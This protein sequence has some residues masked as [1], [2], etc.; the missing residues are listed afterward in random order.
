MSFYKQTDID[1]IQSE[2]IFLTSRHVDI[3][4]KLGTLHNSLKTSEARG[5][6]SYGVMRRTSVIVRSIK[7]VFA[8][9][10]IDRIELLSMD[11]LHDIDINMHAFYVNIFGLLDNLAWVLIHEKKLTTKIDKK[12]VG[13]YA[14]KT[15][16]HLTE[17]FRS[18][19]NTD[20]MIKWHNEYLKNYRD[21]L[22]HRIPLYLP[23]KTLT[24]EQTLQYQQIENKI[25]ECYK[26]GDFETIEK[27]HKE[28]DCIGDVCF[29]VSHDLS[30]SKAIA[31]HPQL[32]ADFNTIEEIVEKYCE[33]LLSD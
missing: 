15:Q 18:Y 30:E 32:I 3:I 7:N 16:K 27:L 13:L 2:L 6:L 33:M 14:K 8:I 20:T 11:E 26:T 4:D 17:N 9:F 24:P 31:L 19:L 29:A 22:S 23:P 25:E 21:A 5:Y 1:K 28:Q 10:P 12:A